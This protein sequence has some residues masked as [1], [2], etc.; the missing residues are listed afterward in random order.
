MVYLTA[1]L[2]P[3][4][5]VA[6]FSMVN[7]QRED[8]VIIQAKTTRRNVAYSVRLVTVTTA[9]EAVTAIIEKARVIIDRKL[10]EHL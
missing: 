8:V 1:I 7:A 2:L 9:E 5:K 6:F 10:E 3:A 4:D